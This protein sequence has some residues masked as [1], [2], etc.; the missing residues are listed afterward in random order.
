MTRLLL[1]VVAFGLAA[2]TA[3]AEPKKLTDDAMGDVAAGFAGFL[4]PINVNPVVALDLPEIA[5]VAQTNTGVQVP[6][7]AALSLP[8]GDAAGAGVDV[9]SVLGND[10]SLSLTDPGLG[11]GAMPAP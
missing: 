10:A 4:P 2:T 3:A 1:T 8:F 6:F 7:S 11:G 5:I 9:G